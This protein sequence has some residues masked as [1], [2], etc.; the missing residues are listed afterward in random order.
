MTL[1]IW[2]WISIIIAEGLDSRIN[3]DGVNTV[4]TFCFR[5]LIRYSDLKK[6][7]AG[8]AVLTSKSDLKLVLFRT[9]SYLF[10][11]AVFYLGWMVSMV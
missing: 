7:K 1:I 9:F 8:P 3:S 2:P 6:T 11:L 5:T 4:D 10:H